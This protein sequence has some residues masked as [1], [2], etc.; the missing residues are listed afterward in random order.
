MDPQPEPPLARNI[1]AFFGHIVEA[2]V[3]E[4]GASDEA[5]PVT[6]T[7]LH[8]ER[9]PDGVILRRTVI[10]EIVLPPGASMPKLPAPRID[11]SSTRR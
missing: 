3:T 7:H 2:I 4:P 8:E 5:T 6:R 9:R 1:G 10:E 11:G